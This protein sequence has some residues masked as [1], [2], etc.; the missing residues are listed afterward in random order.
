MTH[1][2]SAS[3]I[4]YPTRMDRPKGVGTGVLCVPTLLGGR[5]TAGC[6]DQTTNSSG[7]VSQ[8]SGY[9]GEPAVFQNFLPIRPDWMPCVDGCVWHKRVL[10]GWQMIGKLHSSRCVVMDLGTVARLG[11]AVDAGQM[12]AV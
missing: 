1:S 9:G 3:T 7:A 6:K 4:R 2:K 11:E 8:E 10:G 12:T 5:G